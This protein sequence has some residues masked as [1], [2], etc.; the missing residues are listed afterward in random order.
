M[1]DRLHGVPRIEI[2]IGAV[3]AAIAGLGW[4]GFAPV[5]ISL[6]IFGFALVVHGA[7]DV[8]YK[9]NAR[10]DET[11]TRWLE[12][13]YWTVTR[14]ENVSGDKFYFAIWAQ[15]EAKRRVMISREKSVK[16]LIAFTAPI[17]LDKET[18][19]A[20]GSKLSAAQQQQLY[21]DLHVLLASMH[22][23]YNT[24][25]L[26]NMTVQ[27]ALPINE[28]LSENEVDLKAKEVA[29]GIAAARSMIR[30]ALI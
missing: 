23:G 7:Y 8:Y 5:N 25:V 9:P 29:D 20:I 3:I 13:H 2:G 17:E 26:T 16:G 4:G 11:L 22:L 19:S 12:R 6:F 15:D 1:T 14:A 30:R 24:A 18:V 28:H 21:E 27:H 10:L